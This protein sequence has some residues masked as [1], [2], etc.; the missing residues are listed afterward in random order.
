MRRSARRPMSN[1]SRAVRMSIASSCDVR[2]STSN[3]AKRA[4]LS[5]SATWRLRG[6]KRLL[7]LPCAKR[8]TPRASAGVLRSPS[9]S[10]SPTAIRTGTLSIPVGIHPSHG[11]RE[12]LGHLACFRL[13]AVI[14]RLDGPRL[15]EV[16]NGV[17]LIAQS[18]LEIMARALGRRA[19]DDADRTLEA[20]TAQSFVRRVIGPPGQQ[21]TCREPRVEQRLPASGKRGADILALGRTSPVGCGGDRPVIRREADQRGVTAVFLADELPNIQ[22]AA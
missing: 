6:L 10:T 3:V 12:C 5:I 8:T 18:C 22:F 13:R 11:K 21:E 2:R 16:K 15:I 4:R 9:S 7:P 1:R 17:E 14:Q 20:R 19:V